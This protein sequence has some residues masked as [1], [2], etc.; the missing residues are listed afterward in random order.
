MPFAIS[1]RSTT[2]LQVTYN[3]VAS[4]AIPIPLHATSPEVLGVFNGD[5]TPNSVSNPAH[6]GSIVTL[7]LTGA[8]QTVPASI[9][10]EVYVPPL[11]KPANAIEI[12]GEGRLAITFKGAAYGLADGILQVN[13][14]APARSSTLANGLTLSVSEGSTNFILYV[15]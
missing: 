8:G 13:F 1:G 3:S 11:P 15:R 10:G 2:I 14:R 7:Y 9:D 4:N 6:V 5:F 12:E